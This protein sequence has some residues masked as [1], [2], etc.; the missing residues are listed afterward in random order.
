MGSRKLGQ[1]HIQGRGRVGGEGRFH[2]GN[3]DVEL[4]VLGH[5]PVL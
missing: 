3:S 2:W 1:E 5:H 4:V